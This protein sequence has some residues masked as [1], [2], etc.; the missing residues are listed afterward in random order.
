MTQKSLNA[1]QEES[2]TGKA[3]GAKAVASRVPSPTVVTEEKTPLLL[4]MDSHISLRIIH[5]C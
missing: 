5:S 3:Q 2:K 4:R 1:Y